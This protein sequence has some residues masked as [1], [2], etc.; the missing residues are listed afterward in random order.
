MASYSKQG[1][2]FKALVYEGELQRISGW[3]EEYPNLETGGDLF[4]FWTHSGFPV[5]QF[6]LGPG[7]KSRHNPTSFYQDKDYLVESGSLLRS[8]HGLQH[9]GEWHSHHQLGLAQPSQGDE[10]TVF[11]ALEKYKF[12]KFLLF[13][14]NLR[15]N[16]G[17]RCQRSK[18]TVNV[19]SFLF[20][21]SIPKYQVGQWVVLPENSPIRSTLHQS[22]PQSSS[23]EKTCLS[24]SWKVDQTSLEA[25]I[26]EPTQPIE[27]A[28]YLWY[29]KPEGQNLLKEIDSDLKQVFKDCQMF[30]T[31][32]GSIYFTFKYGLDYWRVNLPNNFPDSSPTLQVN[33]G[34]PISIE[35]YSSQ[36][37]LINDLKIYLKIRMK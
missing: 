13:I 26:L 6:V 22:W 36:T 33:E 9:I 34:E 5:V 29:S 21:R 11:R 35:E 1:S 27:I 2:K 14:A 31:V 17:S 30:R 20:T 4:G 28:E 12:P 16:S 37:N 18:W 25:E 8:K 15:P 19:G 24:N 32:T 3:V 7:S 23:F 10:N